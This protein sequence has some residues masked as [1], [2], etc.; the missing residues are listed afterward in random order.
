MKTQEDINKRQYSHLEILKER[1]QIK[2]AVDGVNS[3]LDTVQAAV[4]YPLLLHLQ[5]VFSYFK[6][7]IGS[8][9]KSNSTAN[10]MMSLPMHPNLNN[11]QQKFAVN[12]LID[13][14][15]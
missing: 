13:L 9:S 7:P 14:T 2:T 8:L 3:R 6:I 11:T 4:H 5:P 12:T 10:Q 1:I 15:N